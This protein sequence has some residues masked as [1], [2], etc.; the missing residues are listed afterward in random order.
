MRTKGKRVTVPKEERGKEGDV[1][2]GT[3]KRVSVGGKRDA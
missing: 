3:E 2:G 1:L